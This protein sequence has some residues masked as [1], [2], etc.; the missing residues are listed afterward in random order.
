MYSQVR[1]AALA[2]GAAR[3]WRRGFSALVALMW[4]GSPNLAAQPYAGTIFVDPDIVGPADSTEYRQATSLGRGQ[5]TVFDRR[6]NQFI[7]IDAYLFGITY[8]DGLA[9]EAQ[10]N[11]EFGSEE[12]ARIEAE[13][14]GRLLGQLPYVLRTQ[15]LSLWIHKGVELFGGGNRSVLV[16]TGQTEF[17][18]RDGILEE[19]LFHEASHSSL[20]GLHAASAGWLAAQQ[21]DNGFISTYARDNP[22]R[23]D[24]AESFLLYFAV[25]YRPERISQTDHNKIVGAMP[26]RIRYFDHNVP[27]GRPCTPSAVCHV[28]GGNAP[29]RLYPGGAS[30]VPS[31]PLAPLQPGEA[32]SKRPERARTPAPVRR[33]SR[34]N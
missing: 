4:L 3:R 28:T 1:Q 6:V 10:V 21:A 23:E 18:E 5:R 31:R 11:P 13:K 25:S 12:N 33:E 22:T 20:D 32:R 17:Y 7:T 2:S 24:I 14:Y 27:L 15:V 9:L 16:H 8:G 30:A 19:T 34:S 29:P 26:N